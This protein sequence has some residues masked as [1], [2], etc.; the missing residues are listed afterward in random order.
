[1]TGAKFGIEKFDGTGNKILRE[2]T[3]EMTAAEVCSK[4]E[5]LYMTKSLANKWYLKKKLYTFYMSAGRKIF[6]HIDEFN[7][8]TLDKANIKEIKERSKEKVDDGEGLYV[9]GRTDRRDSHQ[10]RGSQQQRLEVE[11]SSDD[12][13][14]CRGY[15]RLN[16]GFLRFIPHD[17]Q[18]RFFRRRWSRV[19]FGDKKECK[20]RVAGELNANVEE[21]DSLTLVW[22]KK[23]G[24]I[25]EAGLQVLK[26]QGLFGRKTQGR[27]EF[28]E[29]CI[30]GKSHRVSFGVARHTTQGVIDYVHSDLWGL[31]HVESLGGNM[32]FLFIVNDYSRRVLVYILRFKHEAF[33]K[34]KE[35]KQLVENQTGR[36]VNKL[37][38]N[39]RLE[40]CNREFKQLCIRVGLLDI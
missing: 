24:H 16:H 25:S 6:E 20:I 11:D 36:M 29:N 15:T 17:T 26:K 32:Y 33:G 34:F 19:L 2:V 35:W 39:N 37:R 9:R 7:K 22:H 3:G 38:T 21:K 12:G 31:S 28:C 27:L 4:L 30:L 40:F 1:M 23:P 10:S 8:I 13:D 18:F 5:T 14:G